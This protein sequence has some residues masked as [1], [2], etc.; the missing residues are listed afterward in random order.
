[1]SAFIGVVD[2]FGV[3][4]PTGCVVN[5][6]SSEDSVEVK[7]VRN[8]SGVTVM[9]KALLMG[10]TKVT[11]RGK[12]FPSLGLVAAHSDVSIDTLVTTEINISESSDDWPDWDLT[13]NSWYDI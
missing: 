6:S 7:T 10:E 1:M 8:A 12:G 5:E 13:A 9:A 3:T 2:L 4:V 11:L